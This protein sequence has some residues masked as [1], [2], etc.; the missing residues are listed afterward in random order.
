MGKARSIKLDTRE[1]AKAG[2]ATAHF[3][4]MLN[5]YPLG[6]LVIGTDKDDLRA[7]IKRHD[8]ADEKIGCGIDHFVVD[9]DPEGTPTRCFHIVRTD[10]S[11]V[12]FSYPHCLKAKPGD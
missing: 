9:M 3:R 1:F 10:G 11:R 5:R 6:G 4:A 2:D 8:E 12:D 7:L